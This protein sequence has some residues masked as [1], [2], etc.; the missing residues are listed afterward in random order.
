M[1]I[2]RTSVMLVNKTSAMIGQGL[3]AMV[4]FLQHNQILGK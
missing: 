4:Y 2:G 3:G 1:N